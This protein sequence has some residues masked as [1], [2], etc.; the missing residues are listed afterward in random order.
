MNRVAFMGLALLSFQALAQNQDMACYLQWLDG[1]DQVVTGAIANPHG[2]R[3]NG[4]N[5]H[6]EQEF[7]ARY[8]ANAEFTVLHGELQTIDCVAMGARFSLARAN[9][10]LRL[11]PR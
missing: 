4:L 10:L 9:E 1:S 7:F 6:A 11:T 3:G 5:L 2:L 8:S